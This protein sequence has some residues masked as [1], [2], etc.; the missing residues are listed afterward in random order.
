MLVC[1]RKLSI[2]GI[3]HKELYASTWIK[4]DPA[5]SNLLFKSVLMK[6]DMIFKEL[7]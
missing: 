3:I 5:S 7:K 1:L 6:Y 2:Y 4:V